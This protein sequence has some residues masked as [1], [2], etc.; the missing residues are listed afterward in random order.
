MGDVRCAIHRDP[1][2]SA[3]V[4]LHLTGDF[5]RAAVQDLRREL[6]QSFD[7]AR[8]ARIV[9]DATGVTLLG[10]ECIEVLLV[11]YTRAMRGGHGYRIVGA[12]G[13]VRQALEATG[14]CARREDDDGT[15]ALSGRLVSHAE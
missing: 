13:H 11:G 7:R 9:I 4:L 10:S 1:N 12:E 15:P 2:R 3:T 8:G 6:R 5:G 14:L